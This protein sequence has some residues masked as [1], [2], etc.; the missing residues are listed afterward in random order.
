MSE[1]I[2]R[3]KTGF[4]EKHSGF[5]GQKNRAA[6]TV[7]EVSD[8][9]EKKFKPFNQRTDKGETKI[10]SN[11]PVVTARTTKTQTHSGKKR[12]EQN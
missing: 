10:G 8:S 12:G 2:G 7:V 9:A 3:W 11:F 6:T 4:W 5:Y 1:K